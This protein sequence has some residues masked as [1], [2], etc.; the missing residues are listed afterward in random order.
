MTDRDFDIAI[1][2]GGLVG[3]AL[4][5]VLAR[6]GLSVALLDRVAAETRAAPD[7][8][9]RAYAVALGSSRLL[10]VA[11]LWARL[12]PQAQEIRDIEVGEGAGSPALLHFDPRGLVERP[13]GWIVEDHHLRL[14]LLEALAAPEAGATH[15]APAAVASVDYAPGAA[16][17]ALEDGRAITA[18][19]AVAAD[20]RRSALAA[21]AGIGRIGWSYAQTG[22]VAAV[23]HEAEHGGLAHQSFF[24]GGPFAVLPLTGRRSAIVWSEEAGRAAALM[25]LGEDAYL[26]ELRR[27]IGPRLGRLALI[28][29]RWAYPLD[30]TLA[31]RYAAPRLALVG[32]AA[33]GVHP[34]AGQGMN[35]GLRDVAALAEVLVEAA[36]R[37]EDIGAIDVLR[38]YEAW[39][40]FDAGCLALGMD[41]L[42]RLFS[43]ASG[44][45]SV[46]RQAGLAAVGASPAL[47]RALMREAEGLAGEVPRLMRGEPL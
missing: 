42:N 13:V 16:R 3:S 21:A 30:L 28:G 18:R 15:L 36:R 23:A 1:V 41:A 22:L 20:G 19:L 40:R 34:I 29:R 25:R 43:N 8:D 45:L 27:R 31:E 46:L 2:G 9:G 14:A 6:A 11:G 4:A 24:P 38:R 39:R 12:A 5:L 47:G 35:M 17:I 33:H 32:D 37:G 7:F 44:A 26:A 10:A